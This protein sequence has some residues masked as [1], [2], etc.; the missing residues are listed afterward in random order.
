MALTPINKDLNYHQNIPTNTPNASNGYP[1]NVLKEIF[2]KAP[3]DIKDYINNTLIP[4]LQSVIAGD[5]GA[6]NIGSAPIAGVTGD[7]VFEQI[8]N[9]KTLI[10]NLT[11]G[12]FNGSIT[13]DMLSDATG[14]IMDRVSTLKTTTDTHIADKIKHIEPVVTTNVGNVY[15]ATVAGI[16]SYT[17]FL[18]LCVKFNATSTAAITLNLNNLGAKAVVDN[19]GNAITNV[20]ANSI[21]NLR[22]NTTNGNFQ[23]L[24]KGG[25]YGTAGSTQTLEGYTV[26]TTNGIVDGTIKNNA[27]LVVGG[28]N[29]YADPNYIYIYPQKAYYDTAS[30]LYAY[31]ADLVQGNILKDKNILGMIGTL[32]PGKRWA[33]GQITIGVDINNTSTETVNNLTFRPHFLFVFKTPPSDSSTF[34]AE[35]VYGLGQQKT[36]HIYTHSV[37]GLDY[38]YTDDYITFAEN[39]FTVKLFEPTNFNSTFVWYAFE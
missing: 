30:K 4:A 19:N 13:D 14:Q 2:D 34:K 17:D 22:Y 11:V 36:F 26:G 23:L 16:T 29:S 21:Y 33:A 32:E 12:A 18:P 1:T 10:D 3:N 37:S 15:S 35:D 24:G 31:S 25:D 38:Y 6:H 20:K 27:G 9:I 39:G 7:S 5:S 8:Q 28:Y